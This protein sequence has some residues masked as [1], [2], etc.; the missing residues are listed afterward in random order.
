M[1]SSSWSRCRHGPSALR[2][3]SVSSR[4]VCGAV[5]LIKRLQMIPSRREL[6]NY[7]FLQPLSYCSCGAG[8]GERGR[9]REMLGLGLPI[10]SIKGC[11][12]DGRLRRPRPREQRGEAKVSAAPH[13][14]AAPSAASVFYHPHVTT[15]KYRTSVRPSM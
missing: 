9:E 12:S 15:F 6:Q 5:R 7:E 1:K 10:G 13:R 4:L 2:E 8:E 3:T 11:N 14:R